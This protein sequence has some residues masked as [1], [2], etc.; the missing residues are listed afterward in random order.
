MHD[1]ETGGEPSPRRP[2]S[3]E[4]EPSPRDDDDISE[5][6]APVGKKPGEKAEPISE[7]VQREAAA[8]IDIFG[9]DLVSILSED[10]STPVRVAMR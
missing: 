4:A 6:K 7:K 2:P 3:P 10:D 1:N 9:E 8:A 5:D